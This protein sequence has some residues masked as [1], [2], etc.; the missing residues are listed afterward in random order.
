MNIRMRIHK[1]KNKTKQQICGFLYRQTENPLFSCP[2]MLSSLPSSSLESYHH[3]AEITLLSSNQR[4]EKDSS[5]THT[6]THTNTNRWVLIET[7]DQMKGSAMN[8][9]PLAGMEESN[10]VSTLISS[11]RIELNRIESNKPNP[12]SLRN[13]Y[14]WRYIRFCGTPY[15]FSL[16]PDKSELRGC[17]EASSSFYWKH[18]CTATVTHSDTNNTLNITS[19][20]ADTIFYTRKPTNAQTR[21]NSI[22]LQ[23]SL[24]HIKK[25]HKWE[26]IHTAYSL[27]LAGKWKPRRSCEE[28][29][30]EAKQQFISVR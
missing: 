29:Q 9:T 11:C 15:I 18:V 25:T 2:L 1:E 13:L 22:K 4:R 20:H 7:N 14:F 26:T 30:G 21:H 27:W 28:G 17:I 3:K 8:N 6:H 19:A 12:A 16:T 23:Y 24:R 10:V 5:L